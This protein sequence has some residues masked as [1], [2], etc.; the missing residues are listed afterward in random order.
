[1]R[2]NVKHNIITNNV[3]YFEILYTNA[4]CLVNKIKELEVLIHSLHNKPKIIAVTEVKHKN[5]WKVSSSELQ[6]PGFNFFYSSN[7]NG[8]GRGVAH[9]ISKELQCK[10][11]YR[12]VDVE[13]EDFVAVSLN[14]NDKNSTRVGNF[15]KSPSS[16][17]EANDRLLSVIDPLCSNYKCPK[18]FLGDFI[19]P[20]IDWALLTSKDSESKKKINMLQR[21][22]CH[23]L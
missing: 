2:Q 4:D 3:E 16:S 15:Y 11:V 23:S 21:I 1:M 10:Q 12:Y 19:F 6:L 5:K 20:N 17:A 8:S 9:Y 7:L 13:Y 14:G 18:I 22:F